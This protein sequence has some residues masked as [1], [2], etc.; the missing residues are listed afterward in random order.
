MS[1]EAKG[2]RQHRCDIHKVARQCG[3]KLF[4]GARHYHSKRRAGECFS[5][6]TL[7]RIGREHGVAHLAIVLRLI[8]ET[9][10]NEKELYGDTMSA[11]SS[12]LI[13]R[14]MLIE[15]GSALFD[16]LDDIDLG[17]LRRKARSMNCGLPAAHVMRI[18]LLQALE[19]TDT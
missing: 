1:D 14:P 19:P 15:R 18:L 7:R 10:G 16:A 9:E 6:A 17:L 8:V 12:L 13:H 2:Q 3:V 11:I 4:N 5:P